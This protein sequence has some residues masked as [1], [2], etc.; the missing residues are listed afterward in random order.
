MDVVYH[1]CCGLD[2]H[3]K[4]MVACLLSEDEGGQRQKEVRIFTTMTKEI[5]ALADWLA[6]PTARRSQWN[7][8][9]YIG[10]RFLL[11]WKGN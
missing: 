11:S 1:R 6:E 5:L 4:M 9:G 3:K 10:N 2:V 7:Q 8:P